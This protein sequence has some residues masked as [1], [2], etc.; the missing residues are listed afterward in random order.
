M[1][2]LIE[3]DVPDDHEA[4]CAHR[5]Q[6]RRRWVL[7]APVYL[8]D[9]GLMEVVPFLVWFRIEKWDSLWRT[10]VSERLSIYSIVLICLKALYLP[11]SQNVVLA[12]SGHIFTISSEFDHPDG[13]IIILKL[14]GLLQGEVVQLVVCL[15]VQLCSYPVI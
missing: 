8:K 11:D 13:A 15:L 10:Y 4:V 3:I 5:E 12:S 2:G 1:N 9:V 6:V 14:N 7:G